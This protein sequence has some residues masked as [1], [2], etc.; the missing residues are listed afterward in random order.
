MSWR[1][2][3]HSRTETDDP[4]PDGP[5]AR[6]PGADPD[7]ETTARMEIPAALRPSAPT[8]QT[9]E[10]PVYPHQD[11]DVPLSGEPPQH[12]D[13]RATDP[14][15]E[16]MAAQPPQ[17]PVRLIDVPCPHCGGE[18][19]MQ[20]S[21]NDL[22]RESADLLPRD[23]AGGDEMVRVF[24]RNLLAKAPD[25]APLFPADLLT[26]DRIKGQ[27]EKLLAA[28]RAL[29]QVYDPEDPDAMQRMEVAGRAWGRSH[30]NFQRPDGT[31]RG[32]TVEE[33]LAVEATLVET[34]HE[35]L[36]DQ[37]T[38]AY[39]LAWSEAYRRLMVI[40]LDE[41]QTTELTTPRQ[42][43]RSAAER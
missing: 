42:P 30:A 41:Q 8:D 29:P 9:E 37:W 6:P 26:E 19:V 12:S 22:L 16:A 4:S 14:R 43:R 20:Y 18:G 15:L 32:A 23:D 39:D 11:V 35:L 38:E 27:R 5:W 2:L 40:M 28:L 36:G 3:F 10:I 31:V 34:F 25:L 33:Y 7:P 24:Y 21:V 13:P 17:R 1:D